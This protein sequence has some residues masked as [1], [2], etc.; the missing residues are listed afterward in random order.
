MRLAAMIAMMV[1]MCM[2]YG[3]DRDVSGFITSTSSPS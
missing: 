1:I 2:R 3:P